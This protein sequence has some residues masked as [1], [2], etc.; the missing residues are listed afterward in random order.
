MLGL[1]WCNL[2]PPK[3]SI[4]RTT[5]KRKFQNSKSL[6]L[7][8]PRHIRDRTVCAGAQNALKFS[9]LLPRYAETCFENPSWVGISW[10][11]E[12]ICQGVTERNNGEIIPKA[13]VD[14]VL[15]HRKTSRLKFHSKPFLFSLLAVQTGNTTIWNKDTLCLNSCWQETRGSASSSSTSIWAVINIP[16]S[17]P[18]P[19]SFAVGDPSLQAKS[20]LD[21]DWHT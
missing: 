16:L 6:L 8:A 20:P 1:T 19:L 12:R 3:H 5:W 14:S 9:S 13:T 2:L 17:P 11:R 21:A 7:T 18:P 4:T 10:V 15:P